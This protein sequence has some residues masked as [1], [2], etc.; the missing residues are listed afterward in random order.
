[1]FSG[2]RPEIRTAAI[3]GSTAELHK[4]G[5]RILQKVNEDNNGAR[6]QYKEGIKEAI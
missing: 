3:E 4:K 2:C 5:K 6:C 1:M